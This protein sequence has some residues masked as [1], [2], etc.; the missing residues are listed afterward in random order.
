MD[1]KRFDAIAVTLATHGSRR[2]VLRALIGGAFGGLFSRH[3][4]EGDAAPEAC[5]LVDPS[6]VVFSDDFES[7]DLSLRWDDVHGLVVQ[8]GKVPGAT[9]T[10]RAT[11]DD[12]AP[13][14]AR[15]GLGTTDG[16][17]DLYFRVR[18]KVPKLPPSE[19]VYL[20]SFRTAADDPILGLGIDDLGQL[21]YRNHMENQPEV[22]VEVVG[23]PTI[24]PAV[25]SR[26]CFPDTKMWHTVQV[27]L[28]LADGNG[29]VE[30]WYDGTQVPGLSNDEA[31]GIA[32]IGR[33]QLG[34]SEPRDKGY[35]I[36][37]DEV[38]VATGLFRDCGTAELCCAGIC[39]PNDGNN[40][41][42][43]GHVCPGPFPN[44]DVVCD[45]TGCLF[46]C[47]EH[48][49]N[50]DRD[51]RDLEN[52][53][54]WERPPLSDDSCGNDCKTRVAC[55]P[56]E[57]CNDCKNGLASCCPSGVEC[58]CGVFTVTARYI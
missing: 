44:A 12:G 18:F 58:P 2:R 24:V 23:S 17:D 1:G 42:T 55:A 16:F 33:I 34:E 57:F 36:V 37:F 9:S 6:A 45:G 32:T 39:V 22:L 31:F 30:I 19:R 10:A 4:I 29:R 54:E 53:C 50:C 20:L 7:G 27:H 46:C 13:T 35:L 5:G 28:R 47:N 43:C 51:D 14:Y 38:V 52:G 11:S 26:S 56:G 49:V 25:E 3:R 40:C 21:G 15:A 41:V 48:Y 8:P